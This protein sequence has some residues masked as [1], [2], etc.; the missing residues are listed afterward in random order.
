M[1]KKKNMG[2][3]DSKLSEREQANKTYLC[4]DS[5]WVPNPHDKGGDNVAMKQGICR[6]YDK[7]VCDRIYW[8]NC[9]PATG[10]NPGGCKDSAG[11]Q[12]AYPC[13]WDSKRQVCDVHPQYNP[14]F[15]KHLLV[16]DMNIGP[17]NG[18]I[19]FLDKS[20]FDRVGDPLC[21]ASGAA[22]ISSITKDGKLI[23]DK[24]AKDAYTALRCWVGV[25]GVPYSAN[26]P[27][28]PRDDRTL[29]P[30]YVEC[31]FFGSDCVPK[32]CGC[33]DNLN[34]DRWLETLGSDCGNHVSC[35]NGYCK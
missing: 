25:N 33:G 3:N 16:K 15:G 28:L 7:S 32:D 11:N 27:N 34:K 31:S 23:E 29:P 1:I 6:G 17:N 19:D 20:C 14:T 21:L 22:C 30:A 5:S 9:D 13:A 12:I 4:K 18:S 35:T 24:N 26:V 2:S 10:V 8:R